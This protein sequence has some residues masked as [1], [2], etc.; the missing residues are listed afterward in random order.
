MYMTLP[1]CQ[2]QQN[3][4]LSNWFSRSGT[5]LS[6]LF[7]LHPTAPYLPTLVKMAG[8][9]SLQEDILALVRKHSDNCLPED[10]L[11]RLAEEARLMGVKEKIRS[12]GM[13]A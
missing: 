9:R 2:G 3:Q 10:L 1:P 6:P 4:N 12:E 5:F 7:S 11:S 8:A 13:E